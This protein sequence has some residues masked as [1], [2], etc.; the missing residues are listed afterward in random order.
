MRKY[1]AKA[2]N[3]RQTMP[4]CLERFFGGK[5]IPNRKYL[6]KT[7]CLESIY[8]GISFPNRKVPDKALKNLC[9][10]VSWCEFLFEF[11][12]VKKLFLMPIIETERN[13]YGC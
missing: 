12:S 11:V 3:R 13:F 5:F 4:F 6:P 1:H 7:F 2:L 9:A 8:R 10:F